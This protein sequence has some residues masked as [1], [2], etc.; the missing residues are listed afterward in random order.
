MWT[1]YYLKIPFKYRYD[2]V[3]GVKKRKNGSYMRRMKT[4]QE[5]RI[6]C[7]HYLEGIHIRGKRKHKYLVNAWGDYW[8]YNQRN[9]KKFRNKQYKRRKN[10]L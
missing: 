6:N 10:E 8:I 1:S 4:T 9:W 2:P 3:P 7:L 5:R